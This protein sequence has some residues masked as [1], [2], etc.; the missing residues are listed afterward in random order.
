MNKGLSDITN[1]LNKSKT[2]LN[3]SANIVVEKLRKFKE[4]STKK[5]DKMANAYAASV[6]REE[7]LE[8]D[9][10]DLINA[11]IKYKTLVKLSKN[12]KSE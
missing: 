7:R 5:Y 3:N 9:V 11:F 10:K 4:Y 1:E 12:K 2:I 8:G 6:A